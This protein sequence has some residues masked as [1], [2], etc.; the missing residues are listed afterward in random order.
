MKNLLKLAVVVLALG[1]LTF[2]KNTQKVKAPQTKDAKQSQGKGF[3]PAHIKGAKAE[4]KRRVE[5]FKQMAESHKI[6][7]KGSQYLIKVQKQKIKNNPHDEGIIKMA[8]FE[9]KMI[10]NLIFHDEQL[11]NGYEQVA[12]GF[13]H[14]TK[15]FEQFR[16]LKTD[17]HKAKRDKHK[18]KALEHSYKGQEQVAQGFEQLAKVYKNKMLKN[19][20]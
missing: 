1:L 15:A 19:N 11:V 3:S 9:I 8:E 5:F 10:E 13:E 6:Y 20:N 18:N 12:Q 17:K 14:F 16:E 2:C 4:L 7:I